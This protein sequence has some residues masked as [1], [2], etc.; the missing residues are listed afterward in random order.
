MVV[1]ETLGQVYIIVSETY[2]Y[3]TIMICTCRY[4]TKHLVLTRTYICRYNYVSFYSSVRD[5]CHC[6]IQNVSEISTNNLSVVEAANPILKPW[7]RHCWGSEP[8]T[9]CNTFFSYVP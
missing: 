6:T 3:I 8:T 5:V 4:K 2:L 1:I 7:F 9:S